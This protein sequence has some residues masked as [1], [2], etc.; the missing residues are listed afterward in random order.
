M[1]VGGG[2]VDHENVAAGLAVLE[3][4]VPEAIADDGCA[5]ASNEPSIALFE[6]GLFLPKTRLSKSLVSPLE[7]SKPLARLLGA[8]VDMKSAL[9]DAVEVVAES[10]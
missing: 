8:R 6:L 10:S 1:F 2:G 7:S 9:F 4:V 3:A 5:Q